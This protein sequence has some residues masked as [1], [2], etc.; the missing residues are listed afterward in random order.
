MY[1]HVTLM[2]VDCTGYKRNPSLGQNFSLIWLSAARI[3]VL[4]L[5]VM[6][7]MN[8]LFYIGI[9]YIIPEKISHT[10]IYFLNI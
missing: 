4:V 7:I 5:Y 1:V 2:F 6:K 10:F 3:I 9:V 8:T